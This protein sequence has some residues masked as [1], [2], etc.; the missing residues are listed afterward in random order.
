[1]A[2]RSNV[3]PAMMANVGS[4]MK[5]AAAVWMA[6]KCLEMRFRL[7]ILGHCMP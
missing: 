6:T 2:C 1:M 5:V 3:Q 7:F 4:Q